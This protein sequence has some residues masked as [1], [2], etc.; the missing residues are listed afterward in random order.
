MGIVMQ[1]LGHCYANRTDIYGNCFMSLSESN[2][3]RSGRKMERPGNGT[4]DSM[5]EGG[6]GD[7]QTHAKP[8]PTAPDGQGSCGGSPPP[9]RKRGE[10]Q[11]VAG[12]SGG[13]SR[14]QLKIQLMIQR[15]QVSKEVN[16]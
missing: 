9:L 3:G 2:S 14:G 15:V 8:P 10:H 1:N 13:R 16:A 4:E 7:K 11:I 12:A 5:K 6:D